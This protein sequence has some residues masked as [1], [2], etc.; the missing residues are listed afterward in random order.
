MK[1]IVGILIVGLL[2]ATILPTASASA[3]TFLSK[4]TDY[5]SKLFAVGF[6][7][8]N[9]HTYAITGFAFFGLLDGSPL[10]LQ[11]IDIQYDGTPIFVG[12]LIPF[13]INVEYNPA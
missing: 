3:D 1:K 7:R 11:K 8:I 4:S 5:E 12:G 10:V 13:F 2:M 9:P 6:F